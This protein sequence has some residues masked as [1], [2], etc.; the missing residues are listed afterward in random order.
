[1]KPISE[2]HTEHQEWL[3][4]LDFYNDEI[5]LMRKR[6][7]EIVS[8]NTNKEILSQSEH[9][10]NQFTVQKNNIDEIRHAVKQ[11]ENSIEEN[12]S[13]NPTAS[14]HRNMD[15]HQSTTENVNGFEKI[16]N[17]LRHEFNAF[18]AKNM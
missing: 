7:E 12:I 16:F 6:L 8:K 17:E 3:K 18:L 2:L 9:F 11:H 5:A 10:Q 14:D 15:S 1:M 13:A 4:K